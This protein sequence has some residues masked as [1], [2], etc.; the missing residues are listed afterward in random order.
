MVAQAPERDNDGQA[1]FQREF[2]T[3]FVNLE[4]PGAG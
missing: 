4:F 3:V 1:A 2:H